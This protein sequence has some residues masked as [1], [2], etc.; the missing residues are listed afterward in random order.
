ME[1]G[2]TEINTRKLQFRNCCSNYSNFKDL[3]EFK[4]LTAEELAR[5]EK[6]TSLFDR[7]TAVYGAGG[8]ILDSISNARDYWISPSGESDIDVEEE[9]GRTVED[10]EKADAEARKLLIAA[11]VIAVITAGLVIRAIIKNKK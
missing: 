7:I 6:T 3:N 4:N 10:Q 1:T 9:F 5:Q 8:S 2:Y 11:G